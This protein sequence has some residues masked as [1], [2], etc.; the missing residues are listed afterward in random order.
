LHLH[1]EISLP[2]AS[3]NLVAGGDVM[4]GEHPVMVGRGVLTALTRD[5]EFDPF[6]GIR[7]ILAAADL[8]FANLECSLKDLAPGT[9]VADRACIG[10]ANGIG[11]LV[12]AGFSILNVANNHVEQHGTQ[13]FGDTIATL[14]GAGIGVAGL[15]TEDDGHA[16]PVDRELNGVPFR[17]LGYSLRPRQ[18][19]THRPLYAEGQ[20]PSMLEDIRAGAAAGRQVIVSMH[21][22]DEFVDRPSRDQVRLG[23]AMID[24]GASLVLGHHPHVLQGW[25]SYRGGF[26]V[27]SLGNLVFDMPWHDSL[28][29]SALFSCRIDAAGVS[30]ARWIP[31]LLDSMHR[32]QP[33]TDEAASSILAFLSEARTGLES[34]TGSF[35][36]TS[37]EEYARLV[38]RGLARNRAS[39]YGYFL[40]NCWRYE[41]A[42]LRDMVS[43][44]ILRRLG[45]L[46]D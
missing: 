12:R 31:L 32:P 46:K 8:A 11:V 41:P 16:L 28:R 13:A 6:S 26:I 7:P 38:V 21:W 2:N 42:V 22:G 10:P 27:Y 35:A 5:A 23:R 39:G 45:I 29:R 37:D 25:E 33:A 20:E 15:G 40:R 1:K 17:V 14:N 30:E 44:F 4:L 19:F 34:G 36:P 9:P 43:K 24:A 3:F 18:H